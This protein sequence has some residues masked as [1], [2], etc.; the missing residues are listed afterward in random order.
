MPHFP[1][2]LV[3]AG[4]GGVDANMVAVTPLVAGPGLAPSMGAEARHNIQLD[5]GSTDAQVLGFD[6][7]I[8]WIDQKS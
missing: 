5:R 8:R 3:W 7:I 6:Q 4:T 1:R 2:P